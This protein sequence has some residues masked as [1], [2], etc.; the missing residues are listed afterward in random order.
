MAA[1]TPRAGSM[2]HAAYARRVLRGFLCLTL[3]FV[4]F[5]ATD[6]EGRDVDRGG[7][8]S[9][10]LQWNP[11]PL[12]GLGSGPRLG[13]R[14]GVWPLD[15]LGIELAAEGLDAEVP[16]PVM[17]E[18]WPLLPVGVT[19]EEI[20]SLARFGAELVLSPV[21]GLVVPGLGGPA[22]GMELLLG[23]GLSLRLDR[24]RLRDGLSAVVA[25]SQVRFLRPGV[26]VF[27]G[28]RFLVAPRLTV[29]LDLGAMAHTMR[30]AVD[31]W[32]REDGTR[33]PRGGT[34][35]C[36]E[37]VVECRN[38][39]DLGVQA[40]LSADVWLGPP[41]VRQLRPRVGPEDRALILSRDQVA[42]G[43]VGGVT[44]GPLHEAW[45][46]AG[47]RVTV[48]ARG[49]VGVD[50][51][52]LDVFE[53][54][55]MGGLRRDVWRLRELGAVLPPSSVLMGSAEVAAMVVPVRGL[56]ALPGGGVGEMAAHLRAGGGVVG[57]RDQHNGIFDSC[58]NFTLNPATGVPESPDP[59][60]SRRTEIQPLIAVT[61]VGVRLSLGGL[62]LRL[63]VDG[64]IHREDYVDEGATGTEMRGGARMTM[65]LGGTFRLPPP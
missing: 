39:V 8:L 23:G 34:L 9:V 13:G 11:E 27:A 26:R 51:L 17:E 59:S 7:V 33:A 55:P 3:V 41:P 48:L 25:D 37:E 38:F 5:A 16:R 50:V 46:A 12:I 35:G 53:G 2:T 42:I 28:G 54:G 40:R 30:L 22:G 43:L 6:A 24:H 32:G 64:Y 1:R 62:L 20:S 44:G 61:G 65:T 19:G 36:V 63:D 29:R 57:T 15:V 56:L 45:A 49:F 4:L 52:A 47:L 18:L 60:C 10:G 58:N 14:V 31:P 21:R